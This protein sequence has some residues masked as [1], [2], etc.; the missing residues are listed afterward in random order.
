MRFEEILTAATI[1]TGTV[2]LIFIRSKKKNV[3]IDNC[4]SFFPVLFVVLLLRSFLYE[5][6]R[7]PSGSMKPTLLVGDFILVN[8]Y[9]Y[10]VRLPVLGTKL[11]EFGEPKT[12]DVVVFRAEGQD[13]IKRVIGVPGDRIRYQ[14]KKLYI[15]DQ[16]IPTQF[17]RDTY[18]QGVF[19]VEKKE[20]LPSLQHD[21]YIY[22][23]KSRP[24]AYTDIKVPEGSYFVMGDN[25]DNSIDSRYWGFVKDKDLLGRAAATWMSWGSGVRWSRIGKPI[26]H[27]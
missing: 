10:G 21:I 23:E 1:V 13:M 26:N 11:I 5:P 9:D 16:E 19:T 17:V 14:D 22:P 2:S 15:N 8:K 18:D 6:F 24:M 3:I 7:I 27:G 4:K 12:G 25:R 20:T